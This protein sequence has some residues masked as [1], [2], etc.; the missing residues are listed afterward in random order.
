MKKISFSGDRIDYEFESKD[1][2]I[3]LKN[4]MNNAVNYQNNI[5]TN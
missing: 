4:Y 3:N 2:K 1:S 5:D